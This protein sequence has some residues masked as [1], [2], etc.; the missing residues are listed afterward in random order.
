MANTVFA[1]GLEVS[2]KISGGKTVAAFPDPCWSPP[3]PPAGPIVIPYANTAYAKDLSNG[4]TS[5]LIGGKPVARK[6]TSFF[7][8]STGNEAATKSF[9]MG[10]VTGTI[11]GK[12][13]FASWS[14][15]VMVEGY[16]VPRHTDFTTHNHG[17]KPG[18]TGGWAYVSSKAT[19]S[20]CKSSIDAVKK[21]C[22]VDEEENKRFRKKQEKRNNLR[23]KRGK[24]EKPVRNKTWKDTHC[25]ALAIKPGIEPLKKAE[26]DFNEAL[27]EAKKDFIDV[28]EHAGTELI[29]NAAQ[30]YT[31]R[32]EE[33]LVGGLACT[34]LGPEATVVCETVVSM[35]SAADSVCTSISTGYAL[36][37]KRGIAKELLAKVD[38]IDGYLSKIR[39]L[40]NVLTSDK[41]DEA[42]KAIVDKLKDVANDME[43]AAMADPC[44]RAKRCQLVPYKNLGKQGKAGNTAK[45][46]HTLFGE[47]FGDQR[48]CCP[49][50]TGHH[51][52]PDAWAKNG[53]DKSK[54]KTNAAPVVCVEGVSHSIGSHGTIHDAM[55]DIVKE[56]Y[57]KQGEG[58][59]VSLDQAI[60]MAT[61]SHRKLKGMC[62]EKCIKAQLKSYYKDCGCGQ[63]TPSTKNEK[64]TGVSDDS[65]D[66]GSGR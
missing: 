16:N 9:G 28:A 6:D 33:R 19:A 21:H 60:N 52:I 40:H 31:T 47:L 53:C 15:N 29:E 24:H 32:V 22:G 8:T 55:D 7:K 35:Y 61:D 34:I 38:E 64:N 46:Q 65:N 57:E 51:L 12:A 62:N 37:E 5:V 18:N 56:F 10:V 30:S 4:T 43:I 11:M 36:W 54:Y 13:Y 14:M 3:A 41:S 66:S 1:N 23:R 25:R 20:A 49:G 59:T 2:C 39:D 45:A 26:N 42:Y 58:S 27:S 17:S 63:L 44:T 50:Q 48:G